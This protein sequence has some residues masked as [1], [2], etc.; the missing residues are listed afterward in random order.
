MESEPSK[1]FHTVLR[2][3]SQI[4]TDFQKSQVN[5]LTCDHHTI[6]VCQRLDL[7]LSYNNRTTFV[8][9]SNLNI[10]C[11]FSL[12]SIGLHGG[13]IRRGLMVTMPG[14]EA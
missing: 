4:S 13:W 7:R 6:F 5:F 14:S 9:T 3:C 10:G 2:S 11:K 8:C 1:R 12:G